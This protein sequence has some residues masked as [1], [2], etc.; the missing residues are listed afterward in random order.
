MVGL[1][2]AGGENRRISVKKGFLKINNKNI[3][4]HNIEALKHVCNRV[5]ISTNTPEKY[6][7][8]GIPMIGDIVKSQGP[9]IGIFSALSLPEVSSIFVIACDMPYIN[10]K[11]LKYIFKKYAN[12]Y[13]A[14]V[15]MYNKEPQPLLSIYSESVLMRMRESIKQEKTSMRGFLQEIKVLYI[16]EEEVKS[17]DPEGRSF[18]NIN[19]LQ[20]YH[21]E[22][23]GELCLV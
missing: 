13:D 21:R 4:E 23:G 2:L 1:I 18:V 11:L 6:S 5:I 20:D 15:P 9:M 17:I 3:V 8:L 16:S 14:V 22:I 10:V 7:Y 12:P 19:T